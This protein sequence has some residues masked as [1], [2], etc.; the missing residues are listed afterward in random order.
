MDYYNESVVV[1]NLLEKKIISADEASKLILVLN[2]TG[3]CNGLDERKKILDLIADQNITPDEG[4]KL[5]Y[6]VCRGHMEFD[7]ESNEKIKEFSKEIKNFA[8]NFSNSVNSFFSTT[9]PKIRKVT[10]KVVS[11]TA[12]LAENIS[13]GLYN[14]A[15]KLENSSKNSSC[16][17]NQ[18]EE[19]SCKCKE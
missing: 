1:L 3:C 15:D 14:T 13:N 10:K 6:S 9:K 16:C 11:K 18:K 7:N 12:N 19:S 8:N 2:E 4:M 5:L 17:D